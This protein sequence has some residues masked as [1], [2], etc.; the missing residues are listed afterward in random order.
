VIQRPR[1]SRSPEVRAL[2][3][4]GAQVADVRSVRDFAA[5][6]L[7]GAVSIPLRDQ[8]ATWLGWLLPH[9]TPLAVVLGPGQDSADV[10]W[11]ALKIG[12]ERLAGRLDGGM[13][14]W[15]ANGG[16]QDRIELIAADHVADRPVLDIR[17][18]AEHAAGHIPGAVNIEL[19]DLPACAGET[20]EHAV[21]FCGHSERAMTAASLLQRTGRRDL[22]VLDGDP[23]DW[24][25]ATGR[26]LEEGT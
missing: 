4:R 14:A 6:H 16:P 7:P 17:Q 11:Q 9:D 19:G 15:T 23:A 18:S 10:A 24:A 21:V 13:Q 22:A 12:Y 1:D 8:F 3:A 2:L 5:G 26:D 25:T 20:P